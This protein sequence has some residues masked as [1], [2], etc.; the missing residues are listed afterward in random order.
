MLTIYKTRLTDKKEL[1]K[2][3]FLL[4]F[5]L[6]EPIEINFK[7]GQYLILR[8]NDQPRLYSIASPDDQKDSFELLVQIV[9]GGIA[10]TYLD[11]LKIAEEVVFQGPAGMFTLKES[12]RGKIFLVTGTGLAPI[13]SILLSKIK[14]QKSKIDNESE[15]FYLF[16]GL[17]YF[18]DVYLLEELKQ[19][20]AMGQ[21]KFIFKICLSREKNLE[22]IPEEERR[23]FGLGYVT[24][25][26]EREIRE[27]G[28]EIGNFDF[29]LCG[30]RLVVESLHQFLKEKG[31][32]KDQVFFEKF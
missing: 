19:L 28:L 10:S 11:N 22:M 18:S 13:R 15:K 16:W 5:Q 23:Y 20:R 27:R 32:P 24:H 9:P 26:L 30:S 21:E 4:R 17:R 14:N 12:K 31:V 25:E 6:I 29:Y 8:V 1:V 7:A 3:I 2:D